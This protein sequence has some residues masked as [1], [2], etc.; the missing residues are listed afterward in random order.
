MIRVENLRKAYRGVVALDGLDLDVAEGSIAALLGP[1]GAGKSTLIRILA[2]LLRPDS[3]R[4]EVG[5]RSVTA[6]PYQVR[7]LIGLTGQFTAVDDLL[8][9]HENLVL[10][11]RLYRLSGKEAHR[12]ADELLGAFE[13][14]GVAGRRAGTYSGGMRRRLDLAAGLMTRPRALFLDEPTT[15]LDPRSRRTL[16]SAI[17]RLPEQGTTIL[18]TTQYLEEADRLAS[19]VTV[20]DRGRAIATGTPEQLKARAGGARAEVVLADP[21][22]APT[23][24]E[25]MSRY[26]AR[27]T[28]EGETVTVPVAES[29]LPDLLRD[30]DTA[31]VPITGLALRRPTLDDA[32][33]A[34]TGGDS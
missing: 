6:Q 26:G 27:P 20:I 18:L 17:R 23:A 31:G 29:A 19:A 1:N 32:F 25:V 12:L 24:T 34:L 13:L 7:A 22:Q 3:G 15:G 33:L 21:R 16:W 30:L 14:G 10:V 8:T 9:G 28:L 5:G 2:T 4:A 11:G